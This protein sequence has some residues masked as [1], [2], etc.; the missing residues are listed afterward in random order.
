MR[1]RI[2]ARSRAGRPAH[3]SAAAATEVTSG[4]MSASC[5]DSGVVR[6]SRKPSVVASSMADAA[7]AWLAGSDGFVSGSLAKAGSG[8]SA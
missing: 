5:T 8:A 3:S 4:S 7:H 6:A 2:A 1:Y